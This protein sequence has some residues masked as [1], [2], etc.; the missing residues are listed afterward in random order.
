MV[1]EIQELQGKYRSIMIVDDNF[2]ADEKRAHRI[3][4]MLLENGTDFE[5][6][7]EG[8]RVDTGFVLVTYFGI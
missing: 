3:F 8:A 4:D 5:F 7:I 2:L 6:F 1:H